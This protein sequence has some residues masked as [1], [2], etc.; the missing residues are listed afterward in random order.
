MAYAGAED[1]GSIC[2]VTNTGAGLQWIALID[3]AKD[4]AIG[5]KDYE[6]PPV[7][8]LLAEDTQSAATTA[9]RELF[10]A[11]ARLGRPESLPSL[12]EAPRTDT[13]FVR[14]EI[15]GVGVFAV[16]RTRQEKG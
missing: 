10:A 4:S 8:R 16:G 13:S 15:D 1:H 5:R 6:G 3:D 12:I 14:T 11:R 9:K 7:R 2:F